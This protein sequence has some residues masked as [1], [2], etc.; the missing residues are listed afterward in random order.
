LDS[1][2]GFLLL[3]AIGAIGVGGTEPDL[4]VEGPWKT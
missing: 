2:E 4:V 1:L 3:L